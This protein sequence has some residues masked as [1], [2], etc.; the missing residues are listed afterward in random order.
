MEVVDEC[1]DLFWWGCDTNGAF[2]SEA[3]RLGER[4]KKYC[5]YSQNK[6]E[7]NCFEHD[8]SWE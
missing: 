4:D 6:D 8:G 3:A 2:Y 1:G 5:S 7:A